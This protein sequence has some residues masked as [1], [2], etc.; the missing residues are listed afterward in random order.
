MVWCPRRRCSG[1]RGVHQTSVKPRMVQ[2]I[3]LALMGPRGRLLCHYG[4]TRRGCGQLRG[5]GLLGRCIVP[6]SYR[7]AS[8][9]GPMRSLMISDSRQLSGRRRPVACGWRSAIEGKVRDRSRRGET[10]E[11]LSDR[12]R[13]RRASVTRVNT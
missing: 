11:P 7:E 8:V 5:F 3:C 6:M 1:E 13:M 9:F 12:V 4:T 2:T 10:V